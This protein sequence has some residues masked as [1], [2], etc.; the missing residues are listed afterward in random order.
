M[1]VF[2]PRR[3]EW[4]DAKVSRFWDY[5][6]RHDAG[7]FF[8]ERCAPAL[9]VRVLRLRPGNFIDIGCGT[10]ALIEEM[11]R[12][13]V[14]CIGIDSSP[15]V[16]AA[17]KRRT[18]GAAFFE[19]SVSSIPLPDGSADVATL[20]EVVEH[21]DDETLAGALKEAHR[22]VRAGGS[23]L[24]TTPNNEDLS[25]AT[26]QCPDCGAEFHIFQHVRSWTVEGLH[27]ALLEAGFARATVEPVALAERGTLYGRLLPIAHRLLRRHPPRLLA[28]GFKDAEGSR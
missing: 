19:G 27:A 23:L 22:I 8:S 18:P 24:I 5:L 26:R 20:I 25:T 1:A 4:T 11:S 17:A 28:I 13:G 2:D 6:A 21:L 15:D 3:V 7:E 9:A 16:L 14:S 12:R 10:G